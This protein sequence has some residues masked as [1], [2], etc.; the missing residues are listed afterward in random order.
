MALIAMAIHNTPENGRDKLTE[1]TLKSLLQ[2]VDWSRHR[3]FAVVNSTTDRTADMLFRFQKEIQCED[4][5]IRFLYENI[6]TALAINIAWKS[7]RPGEH[8]IKM[9][10][11]VVIHRAG[12]VD[13]MEEAIIRD[14]KIGIIGLKRKDCIQHPGHPNHFY[15][16]SLH[17]IPEHPTPGQK[18]IVVE[19]TADVMGTCTMFNADL[20]ENI[21]YLY[22]PGLYGFDD[23]L[24]CVRSTCAG[25]YNCFLHGYEID[26]ID[27]GGDTYSEWKRR[28]AMTASPE[29][30]RLKAGYESGEISY[31]YNADGSQW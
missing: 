9:D 7:R 15:G 11:D 20:L 5:E 27:P 13:D 30:H 8:A 2:T 14:P 3:F 28:E 12:W 31:A 18:W 26:H 10:N 6:G 16:S 25:F 4:S 17:L 19:K 22:Q 21:G 1:R 23:V 24:A 29:Y